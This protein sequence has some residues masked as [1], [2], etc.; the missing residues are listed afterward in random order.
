MIYVS[1]KK[2]RQ[3]KKE[4]KKKRSLKH[5]EALEA[6]GTA[7]SREGVWGNVVMMKLL[8]GKLQFV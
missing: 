4:K 6:V 2:K 5:T 8:L 7:V 3:K 1:G